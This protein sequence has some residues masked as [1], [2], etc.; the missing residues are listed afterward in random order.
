MF[1]ISHNGRVLVTA[2]LSLAAL[3]EL[4]L[5]FGLRTPAIAAQNAGHHAPGTETVLI[6]APAPGSHA[7]AAPSA[8]AAPPI[9][10]QVVTGAPVFHVD[11]PLPGGAPQ[12]GAVSGLLVD[13]DTGT[14]IWQ[15]GDIHQSLP[16][17]STTKIM[18]AL[19][20]LSNFSPEQKITITQ[21]ALNQQPDETRMVMH[22]GEKFDVGE[23]LYGMMMISAN[24]AATALAV[25]TVGW[26]RFVATMNAQAQA[27]GLQN[28][29]F[30]TPVGLDDPG[31]Y[32]SAYD[33][34]VIA[35]KAWE[36]YPLFR[37]IVASP[38]WSLPHT[39]LH[40]AYSLPN[41][42][43]LLQKYPAAIGV[44]PGW[45]GN[46]GAC[47]VGMASRNGHRLLAVLLNANYPAQ[48]EA[49]LFDWAYATVYG[50]PPLLPS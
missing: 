6:K 23:L 43:Q 33:L 2:L 49:Q 40:G 41:I 15:Q 29:H 30:T 31:H 24:D 17:A 39:N 3:L 10:M 50:L 36:T 4:V 42:N 20:T 35:N 5:A 26:D 12:I 1:R 45:T 18:T 34:A 48:E 7:G 37:Q 11:G 27:L 47:L 14:V 38:G 25:D 21:D 46:A 22:P 9:Q 44:K 13:A 28:S 32:T 8:Q 16:M 19:V